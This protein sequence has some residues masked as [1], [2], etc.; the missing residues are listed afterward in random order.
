MRVATVRDM[1]PTPWSSAP[2]GAGSQPEHQAWRKTSTVTLKTWWVAR[3][4]FYQIWLCYIC[5]SLY[6]IYWPLFVVLLSSDWIGRPHKDGD[7]ARCDWKELS[8]PTHVHR[9]RHSPL[10]HGLRRFASFLMFF[11]YT[12]TCVLGC[13]L[14]WVYVYIC[15]SLW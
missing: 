5:T 2:W 3:S 7:P 13:V 6:R 9:A 10:Y 12:R 14:M 1:S 15:K 4:H 8:V 11:Q